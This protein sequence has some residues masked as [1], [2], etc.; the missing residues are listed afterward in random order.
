[1]VGRPMTTPNAVAEAKNGFDRLPR[2]SRY[3]RPVMTLTAMGAW[4]YALAIPIIFDRFGPQ[5]EQ[6]AA[7]APWIAVPVQILAMLSVGWLLFDRAR[8]PQAMRAFWW[9]ILAF[10]TLNLL[11]NYVWNLPRDRHGREQFDYAD[12]LYLIDYGLLT[13][14]FAYRF[15]R[16]GGTFKDL[17]VWLDGATMVTVQFVAL[18]WFFLAPGLPH[19]LG[20]DITWGAT[21]SYSLALG[22]MMSMGALLYI[23][24]PEGPGR[25]GV[26]LII[27]AALAEAAWE[28]IWLGSWLVDFEFIGPFYNF[29][30]VLCCACIATAVPF[31]QLQP[32]RAAAAA[33]SEPRGDGFLPALAVL[34]AIAMVAGTLATTKRFETWLLVVLAVLGALL[35]ITR[36]HRARRDLRA[37][38]QQLAAREADA[39]LTELVRRSNDLIVV[40]DP[41]GLVSFASP[42]AESI[43]GMPRQQ[44]KGLPAAGLFG[45]SHESSVSGFLAAVS[46]GGDSPD[47]MEIHFERPQDQTRVF[48]LAAANQLANPLINGIVLTAHDVTA[49][50]ELEREVLDAATRERVRWSGAVHDGLGQDLTGIALLLHAAAKAPDPDPRKQRRQLDELV[51]RVNQTI[52]AARSLA[53]GLSPLHVAQ[54]SLGGAL[55]RLSQASGTPMP[56]HVHIDPDFQDDLIDGFSADHLYRIAHEAI[57]NASRYSGGTRIDVHLGATRSHLN[58]DILDDGKGIVPGGKSS[59]DGWGLRL[60]EYRARILGGALRVTSSE[61]PGTRV[62]VAIPLPIPRPA[63]AAG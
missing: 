51:E 55:R 38:N 8:A 59:G 43:L 48:K 44:V 63:G 2:R 15:V 27:G 54:G 28:M 24:M 34:V 42:A 52:V 57:D 31:A 4:T 6:V 61:D 29:G 62:E 14:A 22:A 37:L 11:A 9:L 23:Q 3:F 35:L 50:R 39:R 26:L 1:M 33:G 40:V 32:P 60:M 20:N 53:R 5:P 21:I 16:A 12:A 49:Q 7:F 13:A 10:T 47:V 56:V 45:S 41:G 17:R 36:Q 25:T 19:Q 18:W 46:N 58:L 30:D